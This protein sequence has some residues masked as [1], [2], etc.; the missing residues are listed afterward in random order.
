MKLYQNPAS[1]PCR[2]VLATIF[3]LGLEVELVDVQFHSGQLES[4]DYRRMNPN[5]AVPLLDDGGFY[6]WESTAIMTYLCDKQ[7]ATELYPQHLQ[8]RADVNRW[9]AWSNAQLGPVTGTLVWE[10]LIKGWL[11]IGGPDP[12]EVAEAEKDFH[13]CAKVLEIGRAH[14]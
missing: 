10:N 8:K 14:V 2:R 12:K 9:L 4:P 3:H 1:P 7:G 5:G 6:L 11:K 13:R